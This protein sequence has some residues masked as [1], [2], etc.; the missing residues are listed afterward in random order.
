MWR[1]TQFVVAEQRNAVRSR[2]FSV[3]FRLQCFNLRKIS[4]KCLIPNENF[5]VPEVLQQKFSIYLAF[6]IFVYI[7]QSGLPS[8]SCT[9]YT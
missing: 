2:V 3:G 6:W 1:R 5:S 7:V 4:R 8:P 9:M